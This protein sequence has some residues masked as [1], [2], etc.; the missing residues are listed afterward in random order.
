MGAWLFA[1]LDVVV[2]ITPAQVKGEPLLAPL[3][4]LDC[5]WQISDEVRLRQMEEIRELENYV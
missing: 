5:L 3:I 4:E 2:I 1:V